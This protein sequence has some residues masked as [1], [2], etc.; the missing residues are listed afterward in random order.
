MRFFDEETDGKKTK[1]T[2]VIIEHSDAKIIALA[3]KEY[4]DSHKREKRVRH[5]INQ[6]SRMWNIF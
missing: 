3:L 6:M 1:E 5:L 2:I 4:A